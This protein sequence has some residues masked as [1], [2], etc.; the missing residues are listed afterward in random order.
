MTN[1]PDYRLYLESEFRRVHETLGDIKVQTTKTN[2]RVTHL[3]QRVVE[4]DEQLIQHPINCTQAQKI[5]KIKDDLEEYRVFK[6]YP[7]IGLVI[8]AI[9]TILLVIGAYGT[10]QTIHNT[11]ANADTEKTVDNINENTR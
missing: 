1:Q 5:D 4:L 10:F 8:I 2:S 9:F 7:K 6:K 3:E 11:K